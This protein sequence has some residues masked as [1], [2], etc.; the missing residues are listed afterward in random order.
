M[1][2]IKGFAFIGM[3]HIKQRNI[4]TKLSSSAWRF[5]SFAFR[6]SIWLVFDSLLARLGSLLARFGS[7]L[8]RCGSF[9]VRVGSFWFRVLLVLVRCWLGWALKAPRAL[10]VSNMGDQHASPHLMFA[11]AENKS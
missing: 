11:S 10:L 8:A 2:I 4:Y 5:S 6:G 1:A 3:K 7:V 9:L